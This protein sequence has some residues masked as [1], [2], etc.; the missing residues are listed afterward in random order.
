MGIIVRLLP[1]A[2]LAVAC[3]G[4]PQSD[5]IDPP[6]GY[7]SRSGKVMY[8]KY[9]VSCHGEDGKR[10]LAG[11]K[12]LTLSKMDSSAIVRLLQNGKNGMPRQ[13]QYFQSEEE[14]E[15]TIKYLKSLRK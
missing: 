6:E 13:I 7:Q 8:Q 14:V 10:G 11:A 1:L 9:C 5:I 12:D 15:S 2:L 4:A 3:G